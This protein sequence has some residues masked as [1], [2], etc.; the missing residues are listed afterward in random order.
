[1]DP[2][3]TRLTMIENQ[4]NLTL[5]DLVPQFGAFVLDAARGPASEVHPLAD[6]IVAGVERVQNLR[7]ESSRLIA[8]S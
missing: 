2:L 1:M 8:N 5:R 7:N 3:D 4:I 6:S